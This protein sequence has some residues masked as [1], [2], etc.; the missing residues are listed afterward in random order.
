MARRALSFLVTADRGA[1]YLLRWV[2]APRA[3]SRS[4]GFLHGSYGW[5]FPRVVSRRGRPGRCRHFRRG[6][7]DRRRHAQYWRPT[8]R[9]PRH[10]SSGVGVALPPRWRGRQHHSL[11]LG[12]RFA[13]CVQKRSA[14][15][16]ITWLAASPA[17]LVCR[18]ASTP[19]TVSGPNCQRVPV[20][21]VR[22]PASPSVM[23][24]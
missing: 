14:A 13:A 5:R 20:R 6:V 22:A 4:E 17:S 18:V 23:P 21:S 11:C 9:A 10:R 8:H 16:S 1:R 2:T 7:G 12:A 15:R 3:R 19:T 24:A